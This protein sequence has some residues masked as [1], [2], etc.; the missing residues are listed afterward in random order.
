M[1]ARSPARA[2]KAAAEKAPAAS[3]HQ[4][5]NFAA[6]L[7][8]WQRVERVRAAMPAD[9]HALAM[10]VDAHEKSDEIK[11]NLVIGQEPDVLDTAAAAVQVSRP[12]SFFLWVVL[13]T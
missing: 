12:R 8:F 13:L 3:K 1:S 2:A 9:V 5:D 7:L 4:V 11:G 10:V 6:N